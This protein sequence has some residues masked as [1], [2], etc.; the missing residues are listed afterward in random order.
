ME[1]ISTTC[2]GELWRKRR[3]D[4][5]ERRCRRRAAPKEYGRPSESATHDDKT[6]HIPSTQIKPKRVLRK[7]RT[8]KNNTRCILV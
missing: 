6:M 5:R 4:R 3:W 2:W 7:G 8:V 1:M